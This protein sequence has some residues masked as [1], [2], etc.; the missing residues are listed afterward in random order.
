MYKTHTLTETGTEQLVLW[1]IY[2]LDDQHIMIHFRSRQEIYFF[3]KA[4]WLAL[5]PHSLLFS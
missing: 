4:S 2:G 3:S 1:I 5:W